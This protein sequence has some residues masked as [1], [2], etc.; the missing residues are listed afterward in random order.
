MGHYVLHFDGAVYP[1]NPGGTGTYGYT[2]SHGA[3]KVKEGSGIIGKWDDM[4]NNFAEFFALYKGL[5]HL[6]RIIS[7]GSTLECKGDSALVIKIMGNKWRAKKDKEYYLPYKKCQ[8][9][10]QMIR[11]KKVN[12][13]FTW[14]PRGSNQNSDL[15]SKMFR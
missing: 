3:E 12:V 2:I 13:I 5:D 4:T 7:P 15:L 6:C 1:K 10:T 8:E 9:I 11:K 14:I